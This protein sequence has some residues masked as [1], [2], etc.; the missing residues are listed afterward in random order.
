MLVG[1]VASSRVN[2]AALVE[3]SSF[4]TVLVVPLMLDSDRCCMIRNTASE[5]VGAAPSA[6]YA[7]LSAVVRMSATFAGDPLERWRVPL[8]W[9]TRSES[10]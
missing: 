2:V 5:S 9:P 1:V 6:A 8:T 10:V 7:S 4:L 3:P